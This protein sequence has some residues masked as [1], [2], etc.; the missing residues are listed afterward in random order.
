MARVLI[1]A[2]RIITH[3]ARLRRNAEALAQRGDSVDVICLGVDG[4]TYHGPVNVTAFPAPRY[5][6]RSKTR[7]LIHYLK[8]FT[9]AALATARRSFHQSYD[10]AMAISMPDAVVFGCL[11]A[12][13]RGS[14]VV[15]DIT[16]MMPELYRDRFGDSRWALGPLLLSWQERLSARAA[17]RVFAVHELHRRRLESAGIDP[18]KIRIL[19]NSPDPAVFTP[20]EAPSLP[21]DGFILLYHG[22]LIQRLG[23]DTAIAAVNLLRHRIPEVRLWIVGGG[24]YLDQAQ[25]LVERLGLNSQVTFHGFVPV[26]EVARYIAAADIGLVPNHGNEATHYM[27]PMKLLEYAHLRIPVIAARLDAVRYY[28]GEDCV[29]YF[30]PG[31]A[32]DLADAIEELYRAPDSRRLMAAKSR[33]V[34]DS[35]SWEKQKSTYY[36]A[37]DSLLAPAPGN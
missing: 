16:D 29:R 30:T 9:R 14:K 2:Y 18:G 37:L 5:R 21:R 13:L 27:L 10:V 36:E 33:K 7:Y 1:V 26:T 35:I 34:S 28:F 22:S 24:D 19:M 12:K 6:G 23:I 31:D 25:A 17:D 4:H 20:A 8:F 11:A 32:A 3:D 15:L